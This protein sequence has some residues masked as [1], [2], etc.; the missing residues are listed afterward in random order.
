MNILYV[1]SSD[2]LL[3]DFKK[4]VQYIYEVWVDTISS[5]ALKPNLFLSWTILF[6]D[7]YSYFFFCL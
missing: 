6:L 1:V 7:Y 4:C 5:T 3:Q 2:N